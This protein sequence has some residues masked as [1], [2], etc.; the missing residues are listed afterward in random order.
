MDDGRGEYSFEISTLNYNVNP[1]KFTI[2]VDDI[3]QLRGRNLSR[4]GE[5]EVGL[6]DVA[7]SD[8]LDVFGMDECGRS[9][10]RVRLRWT[11]AMEDYYLPLGV[12]DDVP[13]IVDLVNAGVARLVNSSSGVGNLYTAGQ[14]VLDYMWRLQVDETS[15]KVI[16]K[17]DSRRIMTWYLNSATH[18]GMFNT[19][20]I[21]FSYALI[22]YFGFQLDTL[23]TLPVYPINLAERE[24]YLMYICDRWQTYTHELP[25]VRDQITSHKLSHIRIYSNLVK[26]TLGVCPLPVSRPFTV[27]W[28]DMEKMDNVRVIS[29]NITTPDGRAP[30]YRGDLFLRVGVRPKAVVEA[31]P[32]TVKASWALGRTRILHVFRFDLDTD[33][34]PGIDPTSFSVDVGDIEAFRMH[35]VD[36]SAPMEVC[37]TAFSLPNNIVSFPSNRAYIHLTLRIVIN[38]VIHFRNL[39]V[40]LPWLYYGATVDVVRAMNE[41]IL[42]WWSIMDGESIS[43]SGV[44][45]SGEYF[46]KYLCS[47]DIDPITDF[48]FFSHSDDVGD[49]ILNEFEK[50]A[51]GGV[52]LIEEMTLYT[53]TEVLERLGSGW[54]KC[55][56]AWTHSGNPP[57]GSKVVWQRMHSFK[58]SVGEASNRAYVDNPLSSIRITVDFTKF[59]SCIAICTVDHTSNAIAYAESS[60][61]WNDMLAD[62]KRIGITLLSS[63]GKRVVFKGGNICFSFAMRSKKKKGAE[64]ERERDL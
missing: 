40:Y 28:K 13:L 22:Q 63:S 2:N 56:W 18:C 9:L 45:T 17:K 3:D 47:V 11:G 42:E 34:Y 31:V 20:E 44:N 6:L 29:I 12:D 15:G 37:L 53:S 19:F 5:W 64:P 49:V 7:M 26:G 50:I 25:T 35:R 41:C 14:W 21:S 52:E 32:K 39:T 23:P 51:F 8:G 58:G 27:E 36:L 59:A 55:E 61:R 1:T 54:G 38:D 30:F 33:D 16:V 10:A 60:D 62:T 24:G 43:A 4:R 57:P 48:V 46:N